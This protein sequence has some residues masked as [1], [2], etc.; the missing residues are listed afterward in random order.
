MML[1]QVLKELNQLI[2]PS[3]ENPVKRNSKSVDERV[4]NSVWGFVSAYLIILV[5]FS[6]VLMWSGLDQ[7]SSFSAIAA[8]L[9]NLGPGLGDVSSNYGSLSDFNKWI[10]V[11]AMILGRLEIFALLVLLTPTF[12][13]D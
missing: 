4:L 10:C 11:L 8:S 1:K 3:A 9:N 5:V 12:W 2:H 7:V 13:R 6:M